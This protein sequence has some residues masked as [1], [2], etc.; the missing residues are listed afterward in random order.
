[1]NLATVYTLPLA[2][3]SHFE[4]WFEIAMKWKAGKKYRWVPPTKEKKIDG[5]KGELEGLLT[6]PATPLKPEAPRSLK[7]SATVRPSPITSSLTLPVPKSL[8]PPVVV[9]PSD[10]KVAFSLDRTPSS[11]ADLPSHPKPLA[12]LCSPPCPS[13]ERVSLYKNEFF[14]VKTSPKGGLGCFALTD[15]KG[16]TEIHSEEPLFISSILQVYYNFEQLTPKQQA[17]Y[18]DLHCWHGL[19][20]HKILA[21]FQTN[22]FHISGAKC[23][24]FLNSS[25]FNHACPGFRNCSYTFDKKLNK[26]VFTTRGDVQKGHELTIAYAWVPND[27]YQNYGFFCDC[28]GCPSWDFQY[29]EWKFEDDLRKKEAWD[30]GKTVP[31]EQERY[32]RSPAWKTGVYEW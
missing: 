20:S 26:M 15:I 7:S 11:V 1:M 17:D 9:A 21:I 13:P 12:P 22:R 19:A 6:P 14:E 3:A 23:G 2:E 4:E 25:R 8:K 30:S 29:K 10:A 16:G 18:L 24:I 28:P 31:W 5:R 32:A 27:L